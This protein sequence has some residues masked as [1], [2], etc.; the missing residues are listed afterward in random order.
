[1]KVRETRALPLDMSSK[2]SEVVPATSILGSGKQKAAVSQDGTNGNVTV[3]VTRPKTNSMPVHLPEASETSVR[4]IL[5]RVVGGCSWLLSWQAHEV[6]LLLKELRTRA[7]ET[8]LP[9]HSK[10]LHPALL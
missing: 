2:F 8:E 9:A 5:G 3:D 4:R 1:M 10:L 6:S 7:R